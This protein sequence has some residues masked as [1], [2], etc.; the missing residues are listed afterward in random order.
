[1]DEQLSAFYSEPEALEAIRHAGEAAQ[2][3]ALACITALADFGVEESHIAVESCGLFSHAGV[4]ALIEAFIADHPFEPLP[5]ESVK[6]V[7]F[8]SGETPRADLKSIR[9][10][11]DTHREALTHFSRRFNIEVIL[12][13]YLENLEAEALGAIAA[14][15]WSD[16]IDE[17]GL[18]YQFD[19]SDIAQTRVL[20]E[21]WATFLQLP[22]LKS[23]KIRLGNF[24]FCFYPATEFRLAYRDAVSGLKGRIGGQRDVV[25]EVQKAKFDFASPCRSCRCRQACYH[26]TEIG[27]H[28]EMAEA[29][30]PRTESTLVFAGGSIRASDVEPDADR[31]WTRPVEQGDLL[32]AVLDGFDTILIIDGYFHTKFPCTTLEVMLAI[33]QCVHVFGA[34]SMGALRAAELEAYGMTGMGYV[35]DTLKQQDI[36][37]YHLVAQTYQEDD[38]PLTVP[39]IEIRYFLEQARA[40]GVLEPAAFQA[41]LDAADELH[42]ME[43]TWSRFFDGVADESLRAFYD[44]QGAAA[45]EVKRLDAQLLLASYP[46]ILANRQPGWVKQHYCDMKERMLSRLFAK[47]DESPD[48]TLPENWREGSA[49]DALVNHDRRSCTAE[50][51]IRRARHFFADMHIPVAETTRYDAADASAIVS[52]FLVPFYFLDYYPSSATGNGVRREDAEA[53]AWMEL[54]ERASVCGMHIR[55]NSAPT[56]ADPY[57]PVASLPQVANWGTP[58]EVKD[59]LTQLHGYVRVTDIANEKPVIIPKFATMFHY[60]G[61]DGYAS[62][63]TLSEAVLYALYELVERDTCQ[64]M[65]HDPDLRDGLSPCLVDPSDLDEASQALIRQAADRGCRMLVFLIPN[66]YRLP[67]VMVQVYNETQRVQVHGGVAVRADVQAATVSALHEAWMQ[68]ITY[69]AGTRDDYQPF[70]A[71]K[72]ASIAYA[73]ARAMYFD[74]VGNTAL[75]V[76]KRFHSVDEELDHL[77]RA[78]MDED[79]EHILVADTSPLKEFQLHS[80][81]VIVPRLELWFCP[82]YQPS[83]FLVERLERLKAR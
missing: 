63:N 23:P 3:H 19:S 36:M 60:S 10:A 56:W 70:A 61:T 20:Q 81:K 69:Y 46:R 79:I 28:P 39:L 53:S 59:H 44:R 7:R 65:L 38:R 75:P 78:L 62:G 40:A 72:R 21:E 58:V 50:E 32:A 57:F 73:N 83:P 9:D 15:A 80:V 6:I 68:Y 13:V 18:F 27:E 24:P 64:L 67:C 17:L 43:L 45:F 66:L 29:L 1:M 5:L 71:S 82:K 25:K 2:A 54:V 26:F 52:T 16:A 31:L 37:G 34:A 77:I 55:D 22:V 14:F 42:F 8:V 33:E 30:Q 47:Y 12:H 74:E 35:Y 4:R 51:T 48:L 76:A 49:R 41:A 11:L